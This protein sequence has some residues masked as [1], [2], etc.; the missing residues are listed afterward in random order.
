MSLATDFPELIKSGF[1]IYRKGT[2]E[3]NTFGEVIAEWGNTPV[4]TVDG[5]LRPLTGH[6]RFVASV[7]GYD[8][9]NRLYLDAPVDIREGDKVV[10]GDRSYE[11]HFVDDVMDLGEL[12]QVDMQWVSNV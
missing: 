10:F 4:T 1:A 12:L 7:H 11:V 8:A 9:D 3:Q 5:V 6:R 2:G